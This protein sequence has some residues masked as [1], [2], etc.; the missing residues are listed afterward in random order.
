MVAKHFRYEYGYFS[1]M[2]KKHIGV[3]FKKYLNKIRLENAVK[4]MSNSNLKYTEISVAVGYKSYEHFCRLFR[5][6]YSDHTILE[7]KRH[8]RKYGTKETLL[9]LLK[10]ELFTQDELPF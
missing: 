8:A 2:F 6:Q 1:K 7:V 3:T 5:E 10:E 4:L 9:K